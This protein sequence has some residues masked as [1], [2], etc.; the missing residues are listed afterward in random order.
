MAKANTTKIIVHP[1]SADVKNPPDG[2]V[3]KGISQGGS[4]GTAVIKPKGL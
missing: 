2:G 4:G 3:I 1:T